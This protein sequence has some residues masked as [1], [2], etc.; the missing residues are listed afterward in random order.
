M[1]KKSKERRFTKCGHIEE[2]DKY[3]RT[4]LPTPKS[5]FLSG[6]VEIKV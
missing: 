2:R 1:L 3:P 6:W 5:V 4:A